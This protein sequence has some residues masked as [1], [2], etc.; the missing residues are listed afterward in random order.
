MPDNPQLGGGGT[1]TTSAILDG[2]GIVPV[3]ANRPAPLRG[4][5]SAMARRRFQNPKPFRK[6]NWWWILPRTDKFVDGKLTRVRERK[7]VCEADISKREA[8]RI[9]NEMLRPMNQGLDGGAGAAMRFRD[10]VKTYFKAHLDK[11][12]KPTRD[13]YNMTLDKHILPVFGDVPL[14]NISLLMLDEYF[15]SLGTSKLG[16][17]S[18]LKIKEVISSALGRAVKHKLLTINPAVEV[19]LPDSKAINR[20]KHKPNISPDEFHRLLMLVDEPYASMIFVCVHTGPRVSEL[21]G[22]KW[23]DVGVESLT[24]DERCCRGDWA[25]PK[26]EASHAISQ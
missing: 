15:S 9:A 21:V 1:S 26:T 25:I 19:E 12:R 11:K 18:V 4:D 10:Y 6:G 2:C 8:Q 13:S 7:Q 16:G 17:Y 20:Y 24:I 23:E 14:R 5:F 3:E 22:L